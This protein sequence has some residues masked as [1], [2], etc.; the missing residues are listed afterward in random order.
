MQKAQRGQV[1]QTVESIAR[2]IFGS[3]AHVR[4]AG[5]Q[6]KHTNIRG[7]DLDLM[8]ETRRPWTSGDKT[9]FAELLGRSFDSARERTN[10]ITL[11][12]TAGEVDV[13]PRAAT[14]LPTPSGTN[15]LPSHRFQANSKGQQVV[16]GVKKMA[17]V[18]GIHFKGDAIE[19]ATIK[20]QQEH[21][22]K[23]NYELANLVFSRLSNL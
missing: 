1:T 16:R 12:T 8:V 20:T 7:S 22:T 11:Q 21:P 18:R 10:V 23:A 13:V 9:S 6:M 2:Q 14:F 17:D 5:S 4:H 3:D 15:A 19:R